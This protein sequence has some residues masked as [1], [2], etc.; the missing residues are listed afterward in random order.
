MSDKKGKP[1]F[2][3][4]KRGINS[5]EEG[6]SKEL[7]P[8]LPAFFADINQ[9]LKEDTLIKAY[10]RE[11][12][13]ETEREW[14][15][16]AKKYF[17]V[18]PAC[19]PEPFSEPTD[20]NAD[21]VGE[22]VDSTVEVNASPSA[23]EDADERESTHY[24]DPFASEYMTSAYFSKGWQEYQHKPCEAFEAALQKDIAE[25]AAALEQDQKEHEEEEQSGTPSPPPPR[26]ERDKTVKVV[27]EF[28]Q[29]F[30]HDDIL[31]RES[32][33]QCLPSLT[34]RDV[35]R[36]SRKGIRHTLS[37][38]SYGTLLLKPS[39]RRIIINYHCVTRI[40]LNK[41]FLF[42]GYIG[43]AI[44]RASKRK[45]LPYTHHYL[46]QDVP[47]L[48]LLKAAK[49]VE[50]SAAQSLSQLRQGRAGKYAG[51]R[52]AVQQNTKHSDPSVGAGDAPQSIPIDEFCRYVVPVEEV[53]T[54]TA[55]E[56]STL[57]LSS[58]H[59]PEGKKKE[60]ESKEPASKGIDSTPRKET[61]NLPRSAT[62]PRKQ[63]RIPAPNQDPDRLPSNSESVQHE[64]QITHAIKSLP[65]SYFNLM[66]PSAD[67]NAADAEPTS[68][69]KPPPLDLH[70][71][72]ESRSPR[73]ATSRD[74]RRS[75]RLDL[76]PPMA[77]IDGDGVLIA[78]DLSKGN[79]KQGEKKRPRK[80]DLLSDRSP[81]TSPRRPAD[82]S[83]SGE[84]G[85][86]MANEGGLGSNR[87]SSKIVPSEDPQKG[88]E[89]VQENGGSNAKR[90][91]PPRR[92]KEESKK[93]IDRQKQKD[94][95]DLREREK[96]FV[97][98]LQQ[99]EEIQNHIDIKPE[100]GVQVR[101]PPAA[102]PPTTKQGR[103]GPKNRK[104]EPQ[105]LLDGGDYIISENQQRWTDATKSSAGT[106]REKKGTEDGQPKKT[107]TNLVAP[108]S[109]ANPLLSKVPA[110]EEKQKRLAE[111]ASSKG[112]HREI[113][114]S[115]P[116]IMKPSH[117]EGL[118]SAGNRPGRIV[119]AQS[120]Q[121]SVDRLPQLPVLNPSKRNE[122]L[123]KQT[124][125]SS[126][127][128]QQRF[129]ILT[130]AGVIITHRTCTSEKAAVGFTM[131]PKN[132]VKDQKRGKGGKSLTQKEGKLML[133]N[134]LIPPELDE[135]IDDDLA[136]DS[137][138]E[139]L[140]GGFFSGENSSNTNNSQKSKGKIDIY[141]YHEDG[142]TSDDDDNYIGLDE[143]LDIN[144]N[145]E[146]KNRTTKNVS[147]NKPS[148]RTPKKKS[149]GKELA[150]DETLFPDQEH[151]AAFN[152][153]L[154]KIVQSEEKS[155]AAARLGKA[156]DS[157]H[158]MISVDLEDKVKD[159][160]TRKKV[161]E[162]TEE[163][164]SKYKSLLKELNN[165]KHVQLPLP[166]P[167]SNPIPTSIG[168]IVATSQVRVRNETQGN[169]ANKKVAQ[170]LGNRMHRL[171][172]SAGLT[173]K[174][175]SD[176]QAHPFGDMKSS[177]EQPTMQYMS[178]LKAMLASENSRR[179][180]LNKIKSKTYRRILRK[181][182]ERDKEKKEKALE[183][184][185][186]ELARKRLAEK[187]TKARAEERVT[188]K[189]KNTS[190]WVKHAKKFAQFDTQAK[191]AINEQLSLHQQLMQKM[192]AEAGED[193]YQRYV[194]EE[195]GNESSEADEQL[196]DDLLQSKDSDVGNRIASKLWEDIKEMDSLTPAVAR[197]R[198]ELR[199]M[200]FMKNAREREMK[201]HADEL[202]RLRND[203][204]RSAH[205]SDEMPT[206]KILG[207]LSFLKQQDSTENIVLH[208]EHEQNMSASGTPRS[209]ETTPDDEAGEF[210]G[211]RAVLSSSCVSRV[212]VLPGENP[213]SLT[214]PASDNL[215][216]KEDD[217]L[218]LSR[219][220]D[221]NNNQAY[222][223]SRAFADDDLDEE[224]QKE[225]DTQ[226]NVMLKPDDVNQN[227]PGWGEWGGED[228]RLNKR[229]QAKLHHTE[230]QKNIERS[231][232]KR[233]RADA[234]LDHVIINHDGV[235]LVPDR[236]KLHMVPRPFS[237][238]Q[239]FARSMRQPVGPE[240]TSA[241][242]FV[243]GVQPRVEVRQGHAVVPLDL[244]LRTKK[245]KTKRRKVEL[246][247]S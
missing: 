122:M 17:P 134:P 217:S 225:K 68:S 244:S 190:A 180:R 193:N 242:S 67:I 207:H 52:N 10:E 31:V 65:H 43:D 191:D 119:V 92:G 178:K 124:K 136:F 116:K 147:P 121:R 81:R 59:R 98:P 111:A 72:E 186:P 75:A 162:V 37:G 167:E 166:A 247:A 1:Q 188:Q 214:Q 71:V 216:R 86:A 173:P 38:R 76:N 40:L 12:L 205:G 226:V 133:N 156:L 144:V 53:A 21:C 184:L 80:D 128:E 177:G 56:V 95:Q 46:G 6:D 202:N 233:S 200:K 227:L 238:P 22:G 123:L 141:N 155:S 110:M 109:K 79:K 102:A 138:D 137:E 39:C 69:R 175:E 152:S 30:P 60:E 88:G 45:K 241:L 149:T 194:G 107:G 199:E 222:L 169:T 51:G 197:A 181:E 36:L 171:L 160:I 145:E 48:L 187:L 93:A 213:A 192:E 220:D 27:K 210:A 148:T 117:P 132:K 185:N 142:Q 73:V 87:T 19:R 150:L 114:R 35:L 89:N 130:A 84:T 135:D 157:A 61:T 105:V 18:D 5:F 113:R 64:D 154:R 8:E 24:T 28:H 179:K 170:Q 20:I 2:S 239:E 83:R 23:Q 96:L 108:V 14:V 223:V 218:Q 240:W 90:G 230:M 42:F 50:L 198:Q 115:V 77:M 212:S 125:R 129:N 55:P 231:F 146:E 7:F 94:Q 85:A 100:P 140:Y 103:P 221:L 63:P 57:H 9:L 164:M 97:I 201:S 182:K 82:E 126:L 161:R 174:E 99:P 44:D 104:D 78:R 47:S 4:T 196:V 237:N 234:V 101:R 143:M 41:I 26:G 15:V 13:Y 131:A 168:S 228:E 139:R 118:D 243:E 112:A 235:E 165:S 176:G 158:S 49:R 127:T 120:S 195:E 33:Q 246:P 206:K 62:K 163:N 151:Q 29:L 209:M 159:A 215:K 236:M 183:L 153:T 16:Q 232:L 211:A 91:G 204:R 245:A 54:V 3:P 70:G 34:Y 25:A 66:L 189:H 203:V 106:G 224:F 11:F 32:E 219:A 172:G 229:H 208:S 58:V 74:G